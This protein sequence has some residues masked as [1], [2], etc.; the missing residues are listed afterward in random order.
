M[1]YDTILLERVDPIT[2]SQLMLDTRARLLPGEAGSDAAKIPA[3]TENI[4]RPAVKVCYFKLF[5]KILY[6]PLFLLYVFL[7]TQNP[8]TNSTKF[9]CAGLG[10]SGVLEDE[11]FMSGIMEIAKTVG[12]SNYSEIPLCACKV[13]VAWDIGVCYPAKKYADSSYA[14][15]RYMLLPLFFAIR[16]PFFH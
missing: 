1:P 14:Q 13:D 8:I 10:I 12:V 9:D 5:C 6:C 15:E 11:L 7:F 4:L 16:N 2:G 3:R